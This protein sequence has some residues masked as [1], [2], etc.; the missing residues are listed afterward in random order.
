[1]LVHSHL[2]YLAKYIH[3][4]ARAQECG[5][6]KWR[7]NRVGREHRGSAKNPELKPGHWWKRRGLLCTFVQ[8][9]TDPWVPFLYWPRRRTVEPHKGRGDSLL[10]FDFLVFV[11]LLVKSKDGIDWGCSPLAP[12]W[13]FI[14]FNPIIPHKTLRCIYCLH[15]NHH[16]PNWFTACTPLP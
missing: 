11:L 1:M 4:G 13:V 7:W 14:Q 10:L 3:H 6:S 16:G 9:P 8:S 2:K 15:F 12:E 5:P